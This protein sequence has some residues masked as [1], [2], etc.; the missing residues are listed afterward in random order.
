LNYILEVLLW[1]INIREQAFNNRTA[2]AIEQI[3]VQLHCMIT[4]N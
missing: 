4:I 2:T 3:Y 1:L